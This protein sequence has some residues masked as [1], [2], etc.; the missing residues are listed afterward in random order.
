MSIA[1]AQA[2]LV[3]LET[4]VTA[5]LQAFQQQTGLTIHSVPV[6]ENGGGKQVVAH[7]KVQL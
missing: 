6:S 2:A 1:E 4:Q 7:I 5:L 3:Q